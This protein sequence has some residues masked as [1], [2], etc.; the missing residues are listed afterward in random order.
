[1]ELKE[2]SGYVIWTQRLGTGH[3]RYMLSLETMAVKAIDPGTQTQRYFYLDHKLGWTSFFMDEMSFLYLG[4]SNGRSSSV[5]REPSIPVHPPALTGSSQ[6]LQQGL[7]P[8]CWVAHW[9]TPRSWSRFTHSRGTT[10]GQLGF[11]ACPPA[12]WISWR[13]CSC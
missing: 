8:G 1:M 5:S 4:A 3:S 2:E 12:T 11:L 9:P 10:V 6:Q 7:C 13:A